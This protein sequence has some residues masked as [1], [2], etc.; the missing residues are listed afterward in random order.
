M[1]TR[2]V[3]TQEA[4]VHQKIKK[5]LVRSTEHDTMLVQRSLRN[6]H[7]V[8]RNAVSE[9]V[10]EMEKQ[11]AALEDLVP[12][13]TGQRGKKLLE[14]GDIDHGLQACGQVVGLIND[15]PTVKSLVDDIVDGANDI[16]GEMAKSNE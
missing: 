14:S 11:G 15:I 8:L 16:I 4:P 1:G 2:F 13:I 12:L 6:S 9:K 3:A 10:D 7:R 5:W